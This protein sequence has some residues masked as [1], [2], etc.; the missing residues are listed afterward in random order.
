MMTNGARGGRKRSPQH[1]NSMRVFFKNIRTNEGLTGRT[2]FVTHRVPVVVFFYFF[3]W[4][5]EAFFADSMRLTQR[6]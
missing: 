6:Q 3:S 2:I 4:I 1:G 5:P